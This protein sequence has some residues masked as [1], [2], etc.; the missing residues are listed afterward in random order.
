M[1]WLMSLVVTSISLAC[2]KACSFKSAVPQLARID[3]ADSKVQEALDQLNL[4]K[5]QLVSAALAG[6]FSN[7]K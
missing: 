7:A 6:R 1:A 2:C 5:E 4:L 3:A